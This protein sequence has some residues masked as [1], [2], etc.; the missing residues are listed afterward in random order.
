[1]GGIAEDEDPLAG[2]IGRVDR[3]REPR[4]TGFGPLQHRSRVDAREP[5]DLRHEGPSRADPD[6]NRF[7]VGLAEGLLQPARRRAGDLGIEHDIEIRLAEPAEVGGRR[8]ER[9]R[10][11]DLDA[12][13]FDEARHFDDVVAM[14]EAERRRSEN[15]AARPA[16]VRRPIG[17]GVGKGPH[18]AVKGLGRP[19]VLLALVGMEVERDHWDRQ[20]ERTG[21]TARVVLDQFRR[22]R[23]T[24]QHG[25]RPE[26]LVG[27]GKR[28]LKQLRRIPAEVAGLERRVGDGRPGVTALDHREEKVGVSIALRR[29][30]DEMHTVHRGGDPHGPDMGRPLIGPDGE[31]HGATPSG[32]GAAPAGGRR[33]PR[34]RRPDRSPGWA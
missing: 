19:P 20:G 25:V 4:Q 26:A 11:H 22:A 7:G 8:T 15:V 12:E 27:V 5:R 16:I 24:D 1:M 21:E 2:E 18:E 31:L 29:M 28:R 30:Q 32:P 14:P 9:R 6:R 13:A 3:A 10:H 34:G 33:G 17:L 23:G